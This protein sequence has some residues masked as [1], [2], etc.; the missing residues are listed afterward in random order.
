MTGKLISLFLALCLTLSCA[1]F[2]E[3]DTSVTVTDML[4][5]QITLPSPAARIVALTA[6]DC[7]ILYA[8]GAGETLVGRGA[9]CN[10][11]AEAESVPVVQSGSQTNIEEIIALEPELVL[12]SSMDQTEEQVAQLE[13][14]GIRVV[15]SNADTIADTYESIAI[16]GAVTGRNEEAAALIED[17]QTTFASIAAET[18]GKTIYFEVSPLEY[19]LWTAGPGSFMDEIAAICG[20]TNIFPDVKDWGEVSEEQ[21]LSRNPDYIITVSMYSGEGATP[22][23]EIMGRTGWQD[24]S[25]VRSGQVYQ[26]DNDI[27]T[28]PGP[29]LADAALTLYHMVYGE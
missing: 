9:Y 3:G 4:N 24:V 1:A 13:A 17:M 10:Y 23:E 26:A 7:E 12:M 18:S 11:P 27:F 8:L 5:R 21:V 25:A 29:R 15:L 6:A 22:V 2:A 28:R 20:L 14:A 19:G 16:I